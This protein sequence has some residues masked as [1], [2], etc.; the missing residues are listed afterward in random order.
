MLDVFSYVGAW[1]VRAAHRTAP[2]EVLCVDSSAHALELA[3]QQRA[4]ERARASATPLR[5]MHS[6]CSRRSGEER[7]AVRYRGRRPS[8]LRQAQEGSAE[9]AGRLQA[10]EPARA[11]VSR[12][13]R[14]PGVLLLLLS[15]RAPRNCRTRSPRRR[16]ARDKHLQVLEAGRPGAGPSRSIRPFRRRAIS[17][18]YFC[19]VND[20][21][22]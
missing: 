8:R 14:H 18:A 15:R 10:V 19:R 4:A 5:A 22:K 2:R 7:C 20:S 12:G 17:R 21:L 3:A 9:G 13:R 16:A 11:A 6:T 1:G